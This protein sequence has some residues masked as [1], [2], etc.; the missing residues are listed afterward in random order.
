MRYHVTVSMYYNLI[1]WWFT[2]KFQITHYLICSTPWHWRVVTSR[3]LNI[4]L[5]HTDDLDCAFSKKLQTE[6]ILILKLSHLARVVFMIF[7][8]TNFLVS[9]LYFFQEKE[10]LVRN[11]KRWPYS[12]DLSPTPSFIGWGKF[13]KRSYVTPFNQIISVR[14]WPPIY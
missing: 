5:P 10:G 7:A 3:V 14:N 12:H 4:D 6:Y 2:T 11:S 1:S 8:D 13:A 9:F